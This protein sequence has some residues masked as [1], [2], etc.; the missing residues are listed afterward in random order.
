[1]RSLDSTEFRDFHSRRLVE[2]A[3]DLAC[4]Y[5]LLRGAQ[6]DARKLLVAQYFVE[7]MSA[8]VDGAAQAV[9]ASTPASIDAL[10]A[11]GRD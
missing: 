3:T 11:L 2:M 4:A 7:Q 9:L 8:R 6:R 10:Q 5:L 1:V